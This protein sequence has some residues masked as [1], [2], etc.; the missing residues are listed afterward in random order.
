MISNMSYQRGIHDELYDPKGLGREK[1]DD[2]AH[3]SKRKD[4]LLSAIDLA[5]QE[6]LQ[7]Y[8]SYQHKQYYSSLI[9]ELK[10]YAKQSKSTLNMYRRL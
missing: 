6:A 8:L 5:E 9:R 1:A 4:D 2:I 7:D 10:S 3:F